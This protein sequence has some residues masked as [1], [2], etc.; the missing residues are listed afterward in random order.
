M[1]M[2]YVT[3]FQDFYYTREILSLNNNH[4]MVG[5]G[6]ARVTGGGGGITCAATAVHR[7]LMFS[8]PKRW[9]WH[10]TTDCRVKSF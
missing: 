5:R 4:K 8:D 3:I 6:S 9:Q 7:Q 10:I 1:N 2:K